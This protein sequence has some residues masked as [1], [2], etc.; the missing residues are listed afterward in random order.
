MALLTID[1]RNG[2]RV[3]RYALHRPSAIEAA[4]SRSEKAGAHWSVEKVAERIRVVKSAG[5]VLRRRIDDLAALITREMGKPISEAKAEITKCADCCDYYARHGKAFITPEIPP[6]APAGGEVQFDALGAVLA[7]MPW[8]FPFWQVFRAAAPALLVGNTLLLKHASN[9]S[10]CALAIESVFK[11]A[12]APAGTFQTLLIASESV[13]GLIADRRVHAVTLTG[14]TSAGKKVAAIAG[15]ELKPCVFELGGSDPYLVFEDA[16]LDHAAE[17]CAQARLV[18]TGRAAL[19][20]S[21][22]LS[23]AAYGKPSRKNSSRGCEP[24]VREIRP[25]QPPRSA[26]WHAT[27]FARNSTSKCCKA[28]APALSCSR[29]VKCRKELD[30][31]IP[32]LSSAE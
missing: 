30:S 12:G 25:I 4:L 6:G 2:K 28:S 14:S 1:P 7:I 3:Q 15:A 16:D 19:P 17:V 27:I 26:R 22:S 9:V 24:A 21:G 10:G 8:N 23:S 31:I 29:V 18:N 11:E 5:A 32:P 20:R 13:A